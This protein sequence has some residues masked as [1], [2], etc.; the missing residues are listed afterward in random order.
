MIPVERD[1]DVHDKELLAIV[2]AVTLSFRVDF[3]GAHFYGSSRF[4]LFSL[5]ARPL[6]WKMFLSQFQFNLS[7]RRGVDNV[8]TD[9][10]CRR[11]V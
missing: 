3:C 6:R 7:Y 10:L 9:L 1:Y 4:D 2:H 5:N 8:A 11:I